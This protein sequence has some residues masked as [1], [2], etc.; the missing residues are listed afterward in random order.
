[1]P[2]NVDDLS[3]N[4]SDST[5]SI[6]PITQA[7]A[8]TFADLY[9]TQTFL[10][11]VQVGTKHVTCPVRGE[12]VGRPGHI[13]I[14]PPETYATM[15]N[16]PVLA[17]DYRALGL[18]FPNS[19][20]AQVFPKSTSA[21]PP[22]V[23]VLSGPNAEFLRLIDGLKQTLTDPDIPSSIRAHRMLEPL[24]WLKSQGL[25]IQLAEKPSL[26]SQVRIHLEQDL[27][28]DWRA[29]NLARHLAMSESTLRRRLADQGQ[30]FAKV[31]LHTRLER[32]LSLLQTTDEA[33]SQIALRC[34]FKNPA[35][36]A[37]TFKKRFGI[38][39]K[40]IRFR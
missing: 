15:V 27:E 9:F 37:Q 18:G 12:V 11:L 23:E 17:E 35:H 26:L 40:Q 8:A 5:V 30:G 7:T 33:I 34:G 20:I 1:M 3:K 31:L 16:Q 36:F 10:F 39:P 24:V 4:L 19:M 13:L 28:R 25:H 21:K 14:F 6:L 32:A 38:Q 29:A 22:G 2:L